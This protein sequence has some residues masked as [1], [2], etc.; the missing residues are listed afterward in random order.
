MANTIVYR[1]I[2]S[3]G[4]NEKWTFSGWFKY[5]PEG[6]GGSSYQRIFDCGGDTEYLRFTESTGDLIWK[7]YT[8]GFTTNRVF[9]DPSAFYHIVLRVDTTSASA[10]AASQSSCNSRHTFASVCC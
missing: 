9:R 2:A 1:A 7:S 6:Q 8:E 3:T 5:N 4:D 10:L